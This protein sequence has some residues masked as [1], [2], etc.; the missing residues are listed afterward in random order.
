MIGEREQEARE[1][2][3]EARERE[4]EREARK[5]ELRERGQALL[6]VE[7]RLASSE[8]EVARLKSSLADFRKWA[9]DRDEVSR[10]LL[11]ARGD[12][13]KRLRRAEGTIDDIT[14]SL[15]WRMTA[16]LRGVM[17]LLRR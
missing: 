3:Q 8:N 12:F 1:R 5:R 6:A 11:A 13:E 10:Q 9:A 14:G 16:P 2:E 15:S 17:R 7:T 4:R